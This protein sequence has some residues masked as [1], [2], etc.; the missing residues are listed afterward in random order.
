MCPVQTNVSVIQYSYDGD[1]KRVMKVICPSGTSSCTPSVAGAVTTVYVYNAQGELAE[2]AGPS[3]DTGTKYM[4]ADGLGSTRLETDANG[5]SVRCMDYAPFGLELPAAM[6]GRGSCYATQSYPSGTPDSLDVKFTGRKRDAETGLDFFGARYFSAAQGRFT[7]VDPAFESEN[8]E[9]PQS[10]NRYSYV[11][12]RPLTHTDPDGRCP[13]C[14]PALGVGIAGG[15]VSAGAAA[16]YDWYT[17]GNV[18]ARDVGAAFAGGF[19]AG[20]LPVLTLGTS[21][22][23]E[24]EFGTIAA[25]GAGSNVAGGVITRTLDSPGADTSPTDPAALITDAV[26]GGGGALIG[27]G[28]GILIKRDFAP[29]HP[30]IRNFGTRAFSAANQAYR[31]TLT[32]LD[33]VGRAASIGAGTA[34]SSAFSTLLK[35]FSFQ[36]PPP[37]PPPPPKPPKFGVDSTF[38]PCAEGDPSCGQ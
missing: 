18:S 25:V 31:S 20:G 9:N 1:G 32:R 33:Q 2:E 35:D 5:G 21:L 11:Y 37:P 14:L 23:A 22:V 7:S 17:T 12:N 24:T 6:G 10:W 3:T 27:N 29:L 13:Q 34:V 16:F 8:V 28:V 26:T 38:K 19:V 36:V 4:F 30:P 15:A